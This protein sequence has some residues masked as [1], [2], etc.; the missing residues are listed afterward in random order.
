MNVLVKTLINVFCY[1]GFF[2]SVFSLTII[3]FFITST[4]ANTIFIIFNGVIVIVFVYRTNIVVVAVIFCVVI[5][6]EFIVIDVKAVTCS[7]FINTFVKYIVVIV[8]DN[9]VKVDLVV[10]SVFVVKVVI[11]DFILVI[12]F[13]VVFVFVAAAN[14][15]V[16]GVATLSFALNPSLFVNDIRIVTVVVVI[17]NDIINFV[18]AVVVVA[19]SGV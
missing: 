9:G 19:C 3:N 4:I 7:C 16:R 8:V 18:V 15:V 17:I 5:I 6:F 13:N 2:I 10:S 12:F 1:I 14:V 11:G